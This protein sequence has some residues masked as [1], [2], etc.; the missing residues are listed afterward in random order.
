M[1]AGAHSQS[2]TVDNGTA[3]D[4]TTDNSNQATKVSAN[5]LAEARPEPPPS[6][7]STKEPKEDAPGTGELSERGQDHPGAKKPT[8]PRQTQPLIVEVNVGAS[9]ILSPTESPD[10]LTSET[11]VVSSPAPCQEK[12]MKQWTFPHCRVAKL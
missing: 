10:A 6:P 11:V 3:K 12:D 4:S 8:Q 2:G 1:D 5:T 7:P 9:P